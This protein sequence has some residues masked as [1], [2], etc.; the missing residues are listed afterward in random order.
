MSLRCKISRLRWWFFLRTES[1][2]SKLRRQ[3]K[4]ALAA[5]QNEWRECS[6]TGQPTEF[7][8]ELA[9]NYRR[10]KQLYRLAGGEVEE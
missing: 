5:Y 10:A 1:E 4:H 8:W 2:F 6:L 3:Y 9:T 7:L